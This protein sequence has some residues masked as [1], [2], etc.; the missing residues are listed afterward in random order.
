MQNVA[1]DPPLEVLLSRPDA[2]TSCSLCGEEIINEREVMLDNGV[3]M[4]DLR[5][6]WLLLPPG[7]APESVCLHIQHDHPILRRMT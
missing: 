5:G 1:L 4:S 6:R 3:A 7:L 2:R